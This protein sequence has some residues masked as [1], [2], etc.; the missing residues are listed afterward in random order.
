MIRVTTKIAAL[1]GVALSGLLMAA[2]G[3]G[4][5]PPVL[6]GNAIA[7]SGWMQP[8]D[9]GVRMANFA[10]DDINAKGGL[11]GRQIKAI[12]IDT[13]TDPAESSRAGASLVEQGAAL[14][15]VSCD[16]DQGAPA[17]LAAV[18]AGKL[19]ISLCA[20][21]PKMGVQG[22]GKL[23][24]T[25]AMAGQ[26]QGAAN[27]KWAHD[28]LHAKTA[29]MLTDD[30]IAYSR[31]VCKGFEWQWKQYGD[32]HLVGSD[33]FKNGDPSIAAQISRIKAL[34]QPPQA[35][36][37]CSFMPGAASALRQLR[38][39]GINVPV[40]MPTGSDGTYWF[41]SVPNLDNVY[42][43]APVIAGGGDP[44]PA[45]NALVARY[46]QKYGEVPATSYV[47]YGYALIQMWA[48]GVRQ[49]S[50]FDAEKV[51]AAMESFKNHPTIIGPVSFTP[52]LHIQNQAHMLML[53]IADG[54]YQNLGYVDSPAVP[55]N[56]LF[57]R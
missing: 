50:S 25:S 3:F 48:D 38:A 31:S 40:F 14:V 43:P 52:D 49:A 5:N 6:V 54:K 22:I 16:Y 21:D 11:L 41:A 46:K 36:A 44:N 24:F 34:P 19:A 56:V 55:M 12:V 17:A 15:V 51:A 23:A 26:V 8:Y 10:I 39:A 13:K 20:G 9:Y 29:Y 18:G 1:C 35:I 42:L 7:Q 45:V 28:M 53:K 33:S 2:S 4:A 37:L 32:A 30:T 27:A 57:A 47:L